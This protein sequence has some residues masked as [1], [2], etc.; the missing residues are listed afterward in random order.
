[1]DCLFSIFC[2][3]PVS[4]YIKVLFV[5]SHGHNG[6]ILWI[7]TVAFNRESF[8]INLSSIDNSIL[9]LISAF[10]RCPEWF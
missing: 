8:P 7:I 1:M 2:S 4:S 10:T 6:E 3:I 5:P 9:D